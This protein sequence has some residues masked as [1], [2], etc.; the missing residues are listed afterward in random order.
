[1]P[2]VTR[3]RTKKD[4][5]FKKYVQ[6]GLCSQYIHKVVLSPSTLTSNGEAHMQ[7][8]RAK[9]FRNKIMVASKTQLWRGAFRGSMNLKITS[10]PYC[11][12]HV[13]NGLG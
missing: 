1:M 6:Q 12:P 11:R 10:P 4:P 13:L 9:V 5:F 7:T 8:F 2:N 3:N